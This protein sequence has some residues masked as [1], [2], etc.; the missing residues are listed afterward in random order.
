MIILAKVAENV[1]FLTNVDFY[2]MDSIVNVVCFI[3]FRCNLMRP[4]ERIG[5]TSLAS[6]ECPC[7]VDQPVKMPY[8]SVKRGGER[9]EK[10]EA[11]GVQAHIGEQ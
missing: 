2:S 3:D 11:E 4:W 8:I 9:D 6:R 1:M 7:P 10:G 5:L